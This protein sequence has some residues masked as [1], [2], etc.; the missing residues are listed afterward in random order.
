MVSW[1]SPNRRGELAVKVQSIGDL[2]FQLAGLNAGARYL[3]EQARVRPCAHV[4]LAYAY[5][6]ASADARQLEANY[7]VFAPHSADAPNPADKGFTVISRRRRRR[8]A[9][10]RPPSPTW[11]HRG[12]ARADAC[13]LG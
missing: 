4:H 8:P 11:I 6:I 2:G 13:T 12:I 3:V 5:T 7:L 9:L 1:C 10:P